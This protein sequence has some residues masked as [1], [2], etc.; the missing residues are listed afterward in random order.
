[1]KRH[2]HL[3][4][5]ELV[6]AQRLERGRIGV[7]D[8]E[9][10]RHLAE[11]GV[12]RAHDG[13]VAH[14]G[15][16]AQDLF[17]LR[18]EHLVPPAVDDV[19]DATLDPHEPVGVDAGDV[20]GPQVAVGVEPVGQAAPTHVAGRHAGRAHR[21][22]PH[23]PGGQRAAVVADDLDVDTGMR[24]PHGADLLG[25]LAGVGRG[26]PDDL[27][28]LRLPVA[29][30]HHGTEPGREPAGL[31]RRQRRGD[32]AHVAQGREVVDCVVVGE[33]R[34]RGGRQHGRADPEPADELRE[35][36]GLETLHDHDRRACSQAEQHVVDPGVQ[37]ERDRDEVRDRPSLP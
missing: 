29:V 27:A 7:A 5:D 19:A 13:G 2:R 32:A 9:R 23:L 8:E 21:Q 14:F 24:A 12:G 22:L 30:Q 1:M 6:T 11:A 4:R 3:V 18:R 35:G 31:V 28:D 26:P 36:R 16:A 10:H 20:A 33:H 25:M 15:R 17:D 37:G 34:D